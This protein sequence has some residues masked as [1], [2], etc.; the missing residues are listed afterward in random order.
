MS[1]QVRLAAFLFKILYRRS[2]VRPFRLPCVQTFGCSA[3]LYKSFAFVRKQPRLANRKVPK[4][5]A[6]WRSKTLICT[7]SLRPYKPLTKPTPCLLS[8]A[9]K[10]SICRQSKICLPERS[11]G[12][13]S[14]I[15]KH[16]FAYTV[17]CTASP[18]R[19]H[20]QLLY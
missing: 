18:C 8:F 2:C 12:C 20:N 1:V 6:V 11:S 17:P 5:P 3:L 15:C 16:S 10:S 4:G 7:H 13:N 19:G 9:C 14:T